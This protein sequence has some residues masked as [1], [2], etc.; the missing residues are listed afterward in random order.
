MLSTSP[1]KAAL[2][3]IRGGFIDFMNVSA[4]QTYTKQHFEGVFNVYQFL[5]RIPVYSYTIQEI[6]S[7]DEPPTFVQDAEK[8]IKVLIKGTYS[9]NDDGNNERKESYFEC[10]FVISVKE[11]EQKCGIFGLEL[12]HYNLNTT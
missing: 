8:E 10:N 4:D 1:K 11:F 5:K 3:F 9:E 2:L 12:I 6:H 7:E